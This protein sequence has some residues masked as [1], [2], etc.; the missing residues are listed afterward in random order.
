MQCVILPVF[1]CAAQECQVH[2]HGHAT[3]LQN[4]LHLAKQKLYS[5]NSNSPLL[6]PQFLATTLPLS[7]SMRLFSQ[8]FGYTPKSRITGS[9]SNSV[10][11]FPE[12]PHSVYHSG[13]TI[14]HSHHP[15]TRIH[16][17]FSFSLFFFF[18]ILILQHP[19]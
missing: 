15:C 1:K 13:C 17:H 5:L 2:S 9:Q 14:V 18:L 19:F 7:V 6:S 10:F 11:N 4:S 16:Q 8:L 12:E 3:N